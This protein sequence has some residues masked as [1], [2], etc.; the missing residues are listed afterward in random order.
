MDIQ[1]VLDDILWW[2]TDDNCDIGKRFDV[3]TTSLCIEACTTS[4]EHYK[5]TIHKLS[6]FLKPNGCL[7]MFGVLDETFYTVGEA[8]FRHFQ[9]NQNLVEE[10]LRE[11]EIE[12]IKIEI[13]DLEPLNLLASFSDASAFFFV[14]GTKSNK[15]AELQWRA[16]KYSIT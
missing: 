11:A 10:A 7:L 9:V 5:S 16:Q 1:F 2:Y 14:S 15:E 12:E 13:Y 6:R 3:V 4:E 8:T